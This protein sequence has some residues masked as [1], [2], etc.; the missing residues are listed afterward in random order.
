MINGL[1]KSQL[2]YGKLIKSWILN[3]A[4]SMFTSSIVIHIHTYVYNKSCKK[5]KQ[6]K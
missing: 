2:K 6:I 3:Q 4:E 1:M 5:P